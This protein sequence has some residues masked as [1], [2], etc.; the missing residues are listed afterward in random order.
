MPR[1]G[2]VGLLLACVARMHTGTSCRE[3][4]C[5]KL[6]AEAKSPIA[7]VT[8]AQSM[9]VQ[10]KRAFEFFRMALPTKGGPCGAQLP[11]ISS[12]CRKARQ[13]LTE[14]RLKRLRAL[15]PQS[16]TPEV[17][18]ETPADLPQ[19]PR[20]HDSFRGRFSY[21]HLHSASHAR[22]VRRGPDCEGRGHPIRS[23]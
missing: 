6:K 14:T 23:R 1:C 5:A 15:L 7:L 11:R 18:H 20:P 9:A 21:C 19:N 22:Q 12:T 13:A 2:W 3:P 8:H 4:I 16:A 17:K 10:A